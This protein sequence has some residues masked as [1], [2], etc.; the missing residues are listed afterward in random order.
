MFVIHKVGYYKELLYRNGLE[1]VDTEDTRYWDKCSVL[2]WELSDNRLYSLRRVIF[3]DHVYVKPLK[4]MFPSLISLWV[5]RVSANNWLTEK[6]KF[7]C[8]WTPF[9]PDT[10]PSSLV[11]C[12]LSGVSWRS[13]RVCSPALCRS[14]RLAR[15][16]SLPDSSSAR[17]SWTLETATCSTHLQYFTSCHIQA[18]IEN[19]LLE[20][21]KNNLWSFQIIMDVIVS[22]FCLNSCYSR[23][24]NAAYNLLIQKL[25]V[26]KGL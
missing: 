24:E 25:S 6:K 20:H 12:R 23:K 14:T 13:L 1:L 15:K 5:E 4:L 9:R 18:V 19:T 21:T 17:R 26:R 8:M 11:L 22:L 10:T 16:A 2:S 7:T 3:L